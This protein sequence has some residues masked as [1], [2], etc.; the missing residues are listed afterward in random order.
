MR[1]VLV[2]FATLSMLAACA[3]SNGTGGLLPRSANQGVAAAE[4]GY[5]AAAHGE[6]VY[7][8]SSV[9]DP[10]VTAEL[11]RLDTQA[12]NA[13]LPLRAAAQNG[14]NVVNSGELEAAQAAVTALTKFMAQH[15]IAAGNTTNGGA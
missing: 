4:V 13:L 8:H 3:N 1:K 6:L 5:T 10:A 7:L 12:Y 11:K 9:A 2:V 15:N 14:G